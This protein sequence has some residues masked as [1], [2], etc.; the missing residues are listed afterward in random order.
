[1]DAP[2]KQVAASYG[3]PDIWPG[4]TFGLSTAQGHLA[5]GSG[6][7]RCSAGA[8]QSKATG[9]P[10]STHPWSPSLFTP[11]TSSQS[12][13]PPHLHEDAEHRST[14]RRLKVSALNPIAKLPSSQCLEGLLRGGPRQYYGKLSAIPMHRG[15]RFN[16]MWGMQRY[17]EHKAE[18]P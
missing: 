8:A 2:A 5:T 13:Q 14:V 16:C 1:M 11:D 10:R 17:V 18:R 15:L 4:N 7:R 12:V 6:R 9:S 3:N